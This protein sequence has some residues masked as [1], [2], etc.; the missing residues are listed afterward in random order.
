ML[1]YELTVVKSA[2]FCHFFHHN[3]LASYNVLFLNVLSHY[4]NYCTIYIAYVSL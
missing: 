1:H 4:Q 3:M 2:I